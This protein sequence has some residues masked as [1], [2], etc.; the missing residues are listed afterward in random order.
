MK[1]F[2]D[3]EIPEVQQ[4]A[5][6]LVPD[7]EKFIWQ[8]AIHYHQVFVIYFISLKHRSRPSWWDDRFRCLR[9]GRKRRASRATLAI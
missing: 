8:Q 3:R 7:W 1:N 9:Q 5:G 4:E 6:A 2:L